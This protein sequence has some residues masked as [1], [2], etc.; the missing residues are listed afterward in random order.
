MSLQN[1]PYVRPLTKAIL[2]FAFFAFLAT[3]ASATYNF[4]INDNISNFTVDNCDL[5][6]VQVWESFNVIGYRR[7]TV[8]LRKNGSIIASEV[9]H[10]VGIGTQ[11]HIIDF[12]VPAQEGTFDVQG[13]GHPPGITVYL[14]QLCN[15]EAAQTWLPGFG[16]YGSWIDDNTFPRHVVDMNYDGFSDIVGFASNG[17]YV[18]LNNGGTGFQPAALWISGFGTNTGWSSKSTYP[19]YIVDM[20]RDGYPDVVGFASNG[21]YVALNNVGS[22]FQPAALWVNGFGTNTGWSNNNVY[23]RH[24]VDMNGDGYPDIVGFASNGIYVALS[25]S[26]GFLPPTLWIG[27][28]GTHAGW[29]DNDTYPRHIA[30]MNNDGY[31]DMTGFASNGIYIALN[32]GGTGFQPDTFWLAGFGTN[33]GW[34]SNSAYPRHIVDMN[35]DGYSDMVGFASN[36]IYVALNNGGT[37]F[38]PD[39]YWLGGFG[40]NTGWSN[41]SQYPRYIVDVNN[42]DYPDLV[43]FASNGVYVARNSTGAGFQSATL[44]LAGAGTYNGW[45]NNNTHPRHMVDMNHDSHLDVVGFASNG[46]YVALNRGFYFQ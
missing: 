29:S 1:A 40:T 37:G 31:P 35:S 5:L 38:H 34:S 9:I 14:S 11:T 25:H 27:G 16:T 10:A 42:D 20:N 13:T 21:V 12:D 39:T 28:F 22:G 23:P 2:M 7:V 45:S 15:G 33:A 18:A 3:S 30:D 17:V 6:K 43:G 41:N 32:N 36:G 44:W 26:A 8:N 46:V 4:S 19:R 24:V